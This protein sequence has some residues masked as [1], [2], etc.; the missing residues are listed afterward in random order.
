MYP[1][2][3]LFT[4]LYQT[5]VRQI[6]ASLRNDITARL[7]TVS[8]G[9]YG[10]TSAAVMQS[11]VVRDV[12]N[13]ELMFGQIGNP[14]G[15]AIIVFCGAVAMTAV[16]VPQFLPIYALTIRAGLGVWWIMRKRAHVSNEAFRLQMEH[17]SRRVGEMAALMPITRA[18]GLEDVSYLRVTADAEGVRERGVRLD[19]VNGHFGAMSWVTM[20]LLAIGCL[21]GAA[22]L[23]ILGV[24]P[25][26]PG[27]VVML[28]TYFTTLTISVLTILNFMP[29]IARGRESMRSITEVLNEPDLERNEGKASVRKVAGALRFE[30]VTVTF[31][32]EKTPAL[33][34]I[35]LD[36]RPGE[37]IAF[38]GSS[39]SGKS[40]VINTALGFVRPSSGRVLLDGVDMD[41]LDL[42]TARRSI[43]VV[44]QEST[45]FEGSIR[46]NVTYGLGAVR[47]E[48]V[49]AA[50]QGANMWEVV[51]SL[52]HG[53]DSPVGE[54]GARLS[55]GQRQRLSI[56]RALIRNP[57]ILILDEAT[58]ALD[59][60]SEREVQAALKHLMRHRT[61]LVVAHR[62]STIRHADRIVVLENG[63][64][65]ESGSHDELYARR[66]RYYRLWE[67]QFD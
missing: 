3:I 60:E 50:L 44:P 14:L 56:A 47:E 5:M 30:K 53:V 55:G 58:S 57:R 23:A 64:I 33:R 52:P 18:H 45:L 1:T 6:A 20:Q 32:G 42:R 8:I 15:G 19:M 67:M 34:E 24:V 61:T 16:N 2:H 40:T 9:Y 48:D 49:I 29:I 63:A 66:G 4:R 62:L 11:K 26:T 43:S 51:Q 35:D 21:L 28:G 27:Q 22:A 12:E 38:V 31:A 17:Y 65:S 41:R 10:R 13:I 46:D 37:T 25:I 39:G 59:A 54:R 7:Q 36:I